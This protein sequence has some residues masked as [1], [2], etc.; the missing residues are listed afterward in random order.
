MSRQRPP[1]DSKNLRLSWSL[2]ALEQECGE[3]DEQSAPSSKKPVGNP[4]DSCVGTEECRGF[5]DLQECSKNAPR[6]GVNGDGESSEGAGRGSGASVSSELST[7]GIGVATYSLRE[8]LR[9]LREMDRR[10]GRLG[11]LFGVGG[12]RLP[13]GWRHRDDSG[14]RVATGDPDDGA[15]ARPDGSGGGAAADGGRVHVRE[16]EGS[17]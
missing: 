5:D 3:E 6:E 2:G 1:A 15:S 8:H 11:K 10:E 12:C 17:R 13:D 4:R 14:G 9:G 7:A 16:L